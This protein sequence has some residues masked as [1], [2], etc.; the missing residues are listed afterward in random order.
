MPYTNI[1]NIAIT[2][3]INFMFFVLCTLM[4]MNI[5]QKYSGLTVP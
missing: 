5:A 4:A 2:L 3:C 1:G